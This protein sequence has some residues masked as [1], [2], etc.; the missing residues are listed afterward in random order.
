MYQKWP[1]QIFPVVN[2]VFSRDGHFGLGRGGGGFGGGPPPPLVF[3][4]SKEALGL[5]VPTYHLLLGATVDMTSKAHGSPD[6]KGPEGPPTAPG[7]GG[8]GGGGGAELSFAFHLEHKSTNQVMTGSLGK[9][10]GWGS[11]WSALLR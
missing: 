4:Y 11:I 8:G 10:S 1:D 2:F 7:G 3:N 9:I 6:P 5:G